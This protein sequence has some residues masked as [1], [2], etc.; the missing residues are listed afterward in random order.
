MNTYVIGIDGG[1][2]KSHL[3]LFDEAGELKDFQHWGPLNH[4]V[5]AGSFNQFEQEFGEL[6][7]ITLQ[8]NN[9]TLEHIAYTVIGMAGVD[10]LEQHRIISS[11]IKKLGIKDFTLY[12][13][14]YIGIMAGSP[15]GV[16]IC[17]INGSG[18]TVAGINPEGKMLQIGGMGV[19]TG[20]MGGGSMIGNRVVGAVYSSLFRLGTPTLLTKLLFEKLGI[21]SKYEL[22]E[23]LFKLESEGTQMNSL[24]FQAARQND[25]VAIGILKEMAMSYANAVTCMIR[26]LHFKQSEPLHIVLAGSVFV[27]G[28]H[29]IAIEMLKSQLNATYSDYKIMYTLLEKPPVVGAVVQA[30]KMLHGGGDYLQKVCSQISI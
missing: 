16:G 26:E 5:M 28:E 29:P 18:S 13:D 19:L 25:G 15:T 11:I 9:I 24:A 12:N 7:S 1:S 10:T 4:E 30:L 3:A 20:D 6:L 21:E 23:K 14:A 8:T 2:S 27:K 17:A 22:I